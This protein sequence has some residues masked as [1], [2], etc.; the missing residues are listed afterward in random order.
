MHTTRTLPSRPVSLTDARNWLALGIGG[1]LL[2]TGISRRSRVGA[3]LVVAS[4]PLLYRGATGRWPFRAGDVREN[5]RAARATD[6]GI[7]VRESVRL[8]V[9]ITQVYNYWRRLDNLPSFMAHLHR[10]EET[11]NGR[12]HWTAAGP[13]G[14]SVEWDAEIVS[15]IENRVI[16]WQSLPG[17]E[18]PTAG[19]VNFDT[20]RGGRSTQ[21]RVQ[22]RYAP[23]A[24][25]A[26]ALLAWLFGR[27]PS[28]TIRE[29]MRRFKRILEAGEI[30]RATATT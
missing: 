16:A 28:Q 8:E 22:L 6:Q 26:G 3:G 2:L 7:Q 1:A 21:V 30:P 12:S 17:S 11:S 10:V 29:D 23:P 9:P 19:S 20:V 13:A 25:K 4:A 24:G 5:T 14:V 27:A 18:V 15:E